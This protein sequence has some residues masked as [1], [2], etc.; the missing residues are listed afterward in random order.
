MSSEHHKPS[1]VAV[2]VEGIGKCYQI[3]AR[4]IDRLKQIFAG[5]RRQYYQKFWAAR[6]ISFEVPRGTTCGIVGRNGAGKTTLLQMI[7]GIIQPT[8]GS[9]HA[10]GRVTALLQLG[11]GFHRDVSGRENIFLYGIILGISRRE[12]ENRFDAIAAF[13]EIGEFMDR[14]LRMYS[15]GMVMRLAFAV[16]ANLD[17]DIFIVD[18]ALAVG[19]PQFRHRCMNRF[20]EMKASGTT[21]LYVSHDALA[22][23]RL[24]DQ[25][26]WIDRGILQMCGDPI[27][28]VDA[29][30]EWMFLD[31][32]TAQTD[33][34][35]ENPIEASLDALATSE[36]KHKLVLHETALPNVDR[37]S[38]DESLRIIG[39]GV[40]DTL[41]RPLKVA[42]AGDTIVLRVT[43]RNEVVVST[44]ERL[45]T[46]WIMNNNRGEEITGTNTETEGMEI[47]L[48][49]RGEVITI[50]YRITLPRLQPGS[51]S[52]TLA[53]SRS[54]D[55]GRCVHA[56]RVV[57]ALIF[58]LKAN[59]KIHGLI[60]VETQIEVLL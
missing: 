33:S 45:R 55:L 2:R 18:E 30:L 47:P 54:D 3:Y 16:F 42:M 34:E 15:R 21:I 22:M 9:M 24:C 37:R 28:V 58:E 53:A 56:D 44:Q 51:Y 35:N 52:F 23:K 1:P 32:G 26:V 39:A 50:Q 10:V 17:P 43:I 36:P 6:D 4:P 40:Y 7:A 31:V 57:N 27:K 41:Q 46:G 60:G 48:P 25:V 12:M 59:K 29:Y 14:P 49:L 38:G 13:A 20:N 8:E 5:T 11:G 19:D